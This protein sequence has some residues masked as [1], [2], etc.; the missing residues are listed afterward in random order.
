[1]LNLFPMFLLCVLSTSAPL[2]RVFY[3]TVMTVTEKDTVLKEVVG[4]IR[5]ISP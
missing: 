5:F 2:G 3:L 4:G 1:M